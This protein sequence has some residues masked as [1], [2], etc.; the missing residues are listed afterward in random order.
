[1]VNYPWTSLQTSESI[2]VLQTKKEYDRIWM[3]YPEC[4]PCS[5]HEW[6]NMVKVNSVT[7]V[8]M[9]NLTSDWVMW[10]LDWIVLVPNGQLASHCFTAPKSCVYILKYFKWRIVTRVQQMN[11][12]SM[13]RN[14]TIVKVHAITCEYYKWIMMRNV[15]ICNSQDECCYLWASQ[16]E[17]YEESHFCYSSVLMLHCHLQI[18][19]INY[20]LSKIQQIR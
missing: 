20:V 17:H 12:R 19:L 4:L 6:D 16:G 11:H 15:T 10:R 5:C 3:R 8:K 9:D 7:L 18:E 14:V 1:M 2:W 13:V